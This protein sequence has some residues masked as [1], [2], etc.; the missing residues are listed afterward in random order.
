MLLRDALNDLQSAEQVLQRDKRLASE[1]LLL[2]C[3]ASVLSIRH[4]TV[5]A[6]VMALRRRVNR[7]QPV[8][9]AYP[10]QCQPRMRLN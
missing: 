7:Y 4:R 1:A 9:D 10:T 3:A 5:Q 8:A 2:P 6:C